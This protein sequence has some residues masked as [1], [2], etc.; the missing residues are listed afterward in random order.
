MLFCGKFVNGG[1]RRNVCRV[2]LGGFAVFGLVSSDPRFEGSWFW[3]VSAVDPEHRRERERERERERAGEREPIVVEEE[4]GERER[5]H[6][7]VD[8]VSV[9]GPEGV[10]FRSLEFW[11]CFLRILA[12]PQRKLSCIDPNTVSGSSVWASSISQG[13]SHWPPHQVLSPGL[14]QHEGLCNVESE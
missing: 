5:K 14:P 10:S 7:A 12:L 4:E 8:A 13:F 11:G 9:S 2:L 3:S 1:L 6:S